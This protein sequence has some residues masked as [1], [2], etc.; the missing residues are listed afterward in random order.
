MLRIDAYLI[1]HH[2]TLQR[3]QP[4]LDGRIVTVDDIVAKV[5]P[6]VLPAKSGEV[7]RRY[8]QGRVSGLLMQ[9]IMPK[10]A[11]TGQGSTPYRTLPKPVVQTSIVLTPAYSKQLVMSGGFSFGWHLDLATG[12]RA[13]PYTDQTL[14][15]SVGDN[16]LFHRNKESGKEILRQVQFSYNLTTGAVQ[17]T[18]GAQATYV[19]FFL[20]KLLQL[21]PFA[22]FLAG[23]ATTGG[24]ASGLGMVAQPAAGVGLTYSPWDWLQFS[25]QGNVG[26][27]WMSGSAPTGDAGISGGITIAF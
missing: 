25:V 24:G 20:H 27:T 9:A 16:E 13:A 7:I 15:F 5:R 11:A 2:F 17:I 21:S 14:T 4:S 3:G 19:I 23:V 26:A 12:T 6:L 22:Q 8:V 10:P 1:D 18:K